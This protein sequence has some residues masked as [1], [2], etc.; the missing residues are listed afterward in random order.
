M[1]QL[2]W[3]QGGVVAWSCTSAMVVDLCL[4]RRS[5]KVPGRSHNCKFE[6]GT[7]LQNDGLGNFIFEFH[8]VVKFS[9]CSTV[10]DVEGGG[11]A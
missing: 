6:M 9:K 10:G 11:G 2:L 5:K 4:K 1:L 8:F 3:L 7:S